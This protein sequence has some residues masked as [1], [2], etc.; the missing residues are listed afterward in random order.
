M[1]HKITVRT[2]R[3][4]LDLPT[5]NAQLAAFCMAVGITP[6]DLDGLEVT[7]AHDADAGPFRWLAEAIDDA[8]P[9]RFE[10]VERTVG[11]LDEVLTGAEDPELTRTV[12]DW[13]RTFTGELD[14]LGDGLKDITVLCANLLAGVYIPVSDQT[15]RDAVNGLQAVLDK[16]NTDRLRLFGNNDLGVIVVKRGRRVADPD[17]LRMSAGQRVEGFAIRMAEWRR[18]SGATSR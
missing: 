8:G 5:T 9:V 14:G 1:H 15:T 4:D 17:A 7:G 2:T 16:P 11:L 18:M 13:V 12:F 6:G 10:L 3:G